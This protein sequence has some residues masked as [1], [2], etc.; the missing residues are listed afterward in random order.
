LSA[1][2]SIKISAQAAA[3]IEAAARWWSENRPAAPDAIADDT[4]EMLAVLSRHPGAGSPAR[5]S[6]VPG[7]RRIHLPRVRYFLYYR[8]TQDALEILHFRHS[9]RS[10]QPYGFGR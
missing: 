6:R 8:V 2:L 5:N 3:Q 7:V 4:S 9:A 1:A 10:G